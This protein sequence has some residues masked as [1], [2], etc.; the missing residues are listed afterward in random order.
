MVDFPRE[1]WIR[2]CIS[3]KLTTIIITE[4]GG[5]CCS[6]NLNNLTACLRI[7]SSWHWYIIY[8]HSGSSRFGWRVDFIVQ[9]HEWNSNIANERVPQ[10][11]YSMAHRRQGWW[12]GCCCGWGSPCHRRTVTWAAIIFVQCPR[13]WFFHI[14]IFILL[15]QR[16]EQIALIC[17][18]ALK[19]WPFYTRQEV[20][21]LWVSWEESTQMLNFDNNIPWV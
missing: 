7:Y 5:V 6:R 11:T 10:G 9:I 17:V 2:K 1:V 8:W 21:P 13:P 4:R 14:I 12:S 3:C 19:K 20:A 18:T 15:L 16:I